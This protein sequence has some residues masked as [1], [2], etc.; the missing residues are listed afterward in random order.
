MKSFNV[1][2]MKLLSVLVV[3]WSL[4]WANSAS[5]GV[6]GDWLNLALRIDSLQDT[7]SARQAAADP[8]L[9]KF[10]DRSNYFSNI[11]APIEQMEPMEPMVPLRANFATDAEFNDAAIQYATVDLP[12]YES[13]HDDWEAR[14][15]EIEDWTDFRAEIED[16]LMDAAMLSMDI[17][18]ALMEVDSKLTSAR[19]WYESGG[20]G[21]TDMA[22]P[23]PIIAMMGEMLVQFAVAAGNSDC[24]DASAALTSLIDQIATLHTALVIL[25]SD[26]DDLHDWR[27]ALD[28]IFA[29]I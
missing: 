7:L 27:V 21:I 10:V 26:L 20:A 14:N 12:E 4:G 16:D 8:E 15:L 17:V 1:S 19:E 2:Y 13:D 23:D 18:M 11:A 22:D 25:K 6:V 5:A 28:S 24:D 29:M 9:Q 3:W